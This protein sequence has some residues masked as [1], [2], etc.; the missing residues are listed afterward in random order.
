MADSHRK[1]IVRKTCIL[2]VSHF[3]N[4]GEYGDL[5]FNS[6]IFSHMLHPERHFVS[7]GISQSVKDGTPTHPE[8]LVPCATLIT[9]CKRMIR[10]GI[11]SDE[12]IASL[13]QRHW[14]VATITKEERDRL[15]F[16]L[17]YKSTMPPGWRFEDGDTFAR[18]IEA[19]IIL[20]PT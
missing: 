18:F 13:L 1:E 4:L 16:R 2:L 10:E 14:K 6:R 9:E 3:R 17:K 19:E 7:A 20:L 5:G 11:H 8:H 15:D 12:T